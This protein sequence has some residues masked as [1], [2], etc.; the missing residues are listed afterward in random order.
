MNQKMKKGLL[1]KLTLGCPVIVCSPNIVRFA[2]EAWWVTG[3][4]GVGEVKGLGE[5]GAI[6]TPFLCLLAMENQ[7]RIPA[8]DG[9]RNLHMRR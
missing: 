8:R 2:T 5:F 7:I 9:Q 4:D 1:A 3:E 6:H